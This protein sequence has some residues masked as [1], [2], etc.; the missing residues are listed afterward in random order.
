MPSPKP[1]AILQRLAPGE[2]ISSLA[3]RAGL[4]PSHVS[5][6]L[7]GKRTGTVQAL[8][9]LS[10]ALGITLEKLIAAVSGARA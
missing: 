5:L 10:K 2:S 3:K 8:C 4:S 6:I 9:R 1:P 7:H